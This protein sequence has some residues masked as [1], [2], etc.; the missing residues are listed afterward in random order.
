MAA[1]EWVVVAYFSVV[2]LAGWMRQVS[3]A[4]RRKAA[5]LGSA[6]VLTVFV[7]AM[8]GSLALR[9]WS[10]IVYLVAGYWMPALLVTPTK[11]QP[12]EAWLVR[13]DIDLR[14]L[15]PRVPGA[16]A[17]LLELAYL[18]CYPLVP[19]SFTIVWS[20]GDGL[21]VERFWLA[22]LLSGYACYVTLPW[23]ISRP[24]RARQHHGPRGG[25]QHLNA[26]VLTK[27]SHQFNTFPSGHVAVA[28]AAAVGVGSVSTPAGVA[29]GAVV[30]A[31]SVGAAAGGYHYVLDV[32]LGLIVAAAAAAV[33]GL[34]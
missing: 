22:V 18:L 9:V 15:L 13:A 33:A 7:V 17:P 29:I 2:T 19:L 24:P 5:S 30:A 11:E 8:T 27:W 23:L 4:S 21:D 10:P 14:R 25:I 12:F 34:L 31:I 16:L 20:L 26:H 6:V 3:S 28:A 32:I 1:Y